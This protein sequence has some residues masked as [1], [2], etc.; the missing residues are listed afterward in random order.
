MTDFGFRTRNQQLVDELVAQG[1]VTRKSV[2]VKHGLTPAKMTALF[3]EPDKVVRTT[4]QMTS[5]YLRDRVTKVMQEYRE[6][7]G[8]S[9][10]KP[11]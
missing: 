4:G 10:T 7:T 6:K 3:P 9:Q 8:A 1:Y 2:M 5:L 11:G